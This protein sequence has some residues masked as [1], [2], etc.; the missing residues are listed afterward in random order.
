MIGSRFDSRPNNAIAGTKAKNECSSEL[1][2]YV[3][4]LGS[5][6]DQ[7]S[8]SATTCGSG[9]LISNSIADYQKINQL[10][11][12]AVAAHGPNRCRYSS[13]VMNALTI[14][15]LT[16]LPLKAFSFVSPKSDPV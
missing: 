3:K 8:Q 15:A 6:P 2:D 9:R 1:R 4:T 7:V 16:K 11:R 5:C 14:S 10:L 12:Q 13:E